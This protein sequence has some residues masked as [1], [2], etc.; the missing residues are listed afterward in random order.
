M[1]ARLAFVKQPWTWVAALTVLVLAQTVL[2]PRVRA[3]DSTSSAKAERKNVLVLGDSLAAGY[4][5]DPDQAFPALLQKKVDAAG[6]PFSVINAGVSGDTTAGGLRRMDWL[7]KR[8]VDVLLLEL[9]ANDGLRGI[10]LQAMKSNL[11]AIIDRTKGKYPHAQI[12]ILGMKM[13]PNLG[14]YASDFEKVFPELAKQ[15]DA[16]LIPFLLDGVGGRP[17]LNLSDRI[18]PTAEGQKLLAEN[19]WKVLQPLLQQIYVAK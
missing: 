10:S 3:S 15:N 9:G 6:W 14:E 19:V 11:Q 13:P 17:E 18:H 1:K 12:V 8:K 16:A 7:L 5:L 4:G 2:V